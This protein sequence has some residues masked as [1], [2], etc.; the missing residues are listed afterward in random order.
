MSGANP[1]T[2]LDELRR[3]ID[4]VDGLLLELV[5]KRVSLVLAVGEYKRKHGLP[6]Y[7]PARESQVLDRLSQAPPAPLDKETVRRVFERV[8]DESRRLEQHHVQR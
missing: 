8:I 1:G 5:A 7:D 2:D 4:K 3:E 6:V